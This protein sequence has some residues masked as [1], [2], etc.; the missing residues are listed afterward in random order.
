MLVGVAMIAI[1]YGPG[2]WTGGFGDQDVRSKFTES[3]GVFKAL[4]PPIWFKGIPLW[5]ATFSVGLFIGW[6]SSREPSIAVVDRFMSEFDDDVLSR[7]HPA[8][9][10]D[11]FWGANHYLDARPIPWITP[12]GERRA[13]FKKLTDFI[14]SGG[15]TAANGWRHRPNGCD[16]FRW[17]LVLGGAGSGKS[18]IAHRVA[19]ILSAEPQARNRRVAVWLRGHLPCLRRELDDPF[20]AG[21]L[22]PEGARHDSPTTAHPYPNW[23]GRTEAVGQ[24]LERLKLWRPRRPTILILDDP[25]PGSS[26]EVIAALSASSAEYRYPVRLVIINQTIPRELAISRTDTGILYSRLPS[27]DQNP[28]I[29]TENSNFTLADMVQIRSHLSGN[30]AYHLAGTSA[31]LHLLSVTR[32]LPL[33]VELGLAWLGS[34]NPLSGMSEAALIT[35]RVER[36]IEALRLGGLNKTESLNAVAAATIAN[37]GRR[38]TIEKVFGQLNL[39]NEE[40]TFPISVDEAETSDFIPPIRP[41][42]IGLA[43]V[44]NR[45]EQSPDVEDTAVLLVKTAWEANAFGTLDS[46]LRWGLT[47][48]ALG[49]ALTAD[50]P[51]SVSLGETGADLALS[52]SE[53]AII[54]PTT[55]W[56]NEAKEETPVLRLACK[57]IYNVSGIDIF[58]RLGE[59]VNI[60]DV[61]GGSIIRGAAYNRI[62][63]DVFYVSSKEGMTEVLDIQ[64]IFKF[65]TI[66]IATMNKWSESRNAITDKGNDGLIAHFNRYFNFPSSERNTE[67]FASLAIEMLLQLE[68]TV[69]PFSSF[70]PG[71]VRVL[72]STFGNIPFADETVGRVYMHLIDALL[73]ALFDDAEECYRQFDGAMIAVAAK[74]SDEGFRAVSDAAGRL[75]IKSEWPPTRFSFFDLHKLYLEH[76]KVV[77]LG[78]TVVDCMQE[79]QKF[80]GNGDLSQARDSLDEILKICQESDIP[81]LLYASSKAV[82][83]YLLVCS[84]KEFLDIRVSA[85]HLIDQLNTINVADNDNCYLDILI[86]RLKYSVFSAAVRFDMMG[87]ANSEIQKLERHGQ[88]FIGRREISLILIDSWIELAWAYMNKGSMN[89]ID[90]AFERV[91]YWGNFF[92][93][94]IGFIEKRENLIACEAATAVGARTPSRAEAAAKKLDDAA[95]AHDI[96]REEQSLNLLNLHRFESWLNATRTFLDD[97]KLDLAKEFMTIAMDRGK[98]LEHIP[99]D[100]EKFIQKLNDQLN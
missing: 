58:Q 100:L 81:L 40:S 53:R 23:R 49:L 24:W 75:I 44:R 85:Y 16:P 93:S 66:W 19:E 46:V 90:M 97:G 77:T 48:D 86:V 63:S 57:Q 4:I 68:H 38:A 78:M 79:I 56:R 2:L 45:I 99:N 18:R 69:A 55:D 28:V 96:N 88:L 1:V 14:R 15:A 3:L 92:A 12:S 52:L 91:E 36:I 62:I 33:L 17:T 87:I 82:M 89:T 22:R 32:G 71:S 74:S 72:R 11:P 47:P 9:A 73:A 83:E 8:K 84:A 61:V 76:G 50:I 42:M 7:V 59:F 98:L 5:L 70:R 37:G 34:G 35:G 41:R 6:K 54:V 31:L 30:L 67:I 64:S 13:N 39:N 10:F 29:V 27:F 60:S 65:W 94:D 95:I 21:W 80:A 43:F 26:R 25:T 51:E 20:D